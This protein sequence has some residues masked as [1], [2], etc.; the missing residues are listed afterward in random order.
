MQTLQDDKITT[1][2]STQAQFPFRLNFHAPKG[3]FKIIH[4]A[5]ILPD[6]PA[7]L[8][9]FN[10]INLMGQPKIPMLRNES[11]IH[12][13]AL[14]TVACMSSVSAHMV[15]HFHS[16]SM[17]Q[18]CQFTE[19]SSAQLIQQH[20][21][22]S[23]REALSGQLPRFQLQRHDSELAV[24]LHIETLPVLSHLSK[25]KL[26]IYD[27]WSLMCRCQGQLI[28]KNQKF[29]I[30]QLGAFAFARSINM[31]YLP[32]SFMS[33]QV[34][35]LPQCRQLILMQVRNAF[36]QVMQSRLFLRDLNW[37][38]SELF[39]EQV[40]FKV[41]RVYPKITTPNG[42]HMYLPRQ[43]EWCLDHPQLKLHL[44]AE[45]R[46]DYKFGLGAGYVGSFRYQLRLN[47]ESIE[48]ESGYCE[49]IDCRHLKFQEKME[50]LKMKDA[51]ANTVPC[52]LKK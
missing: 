33:Y 17:S 6:L 34:I 19:Q 30:D 7:P 21:Q 43:F 45:S 31:P 51:L 36:N 38:K 4:Q 10:F 35:N 37:E 25:S 42:Q 32:L 16:Y 20:F 15:G 47:D 5:L 52:T 28:Y 2:S 49:Y 24:D 3:R 18:T 48:G 27:H 11:A 9:Y 50:Q 8:H 41:N 44:V 39:D 1:P 13:Q 26:G 14:D 23:E 29:E 46:G 22:Y 40:F 12:T